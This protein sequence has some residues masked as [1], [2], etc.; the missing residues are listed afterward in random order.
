MLELSGYR[1]RIGSAIGVSG[2]ATRYR[3][4]GLPGTIGSDMQSGSRAKLVIVKKMTHRAL[5]RIRLPGNWLNREHL[6]LSGQ[7]ADREIM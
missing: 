4:I 7:S 6:D 5:A 3:A 2:N 1:A